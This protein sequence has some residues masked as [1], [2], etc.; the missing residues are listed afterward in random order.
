MQVLC[1]ERI[2]SALLRRLKSPD[3]LRP[4]DPDLTSAAFAPAPGARSLCGEV[5]R[6]VREG[7]RC[8]SH[9]LASL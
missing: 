6:L 1:T 9:T 8:C 5:A 3:G 7:G 2:D 4:V